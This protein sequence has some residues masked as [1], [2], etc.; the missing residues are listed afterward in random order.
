MR[1]S[2]PDLWF[3]RARMLLGLLF[4]GSVL[5]GC[6]SSSFLGRQFTDFRAYYNTF[7]NARKSFD[8]GVRGL[9]AQQE[10]PIDP[11]AYLTLFG[12]PTR[13]ANAAAFN[14][15][16][17]K[18]AEVVRRH[19][20][21][22]WVDDALMLIGQSYFYLGNY[23]GAAQKFREVIALGGAKELEARF[24][25]ARSLVAARSFDEAQTVLQETLAREA[26]PTD[27]RSR[28]LLLQADLYVQQ[29][30]W[31]E[32]RQALEAGLQRVPERSLG[33]KGYFLL[34]QVC[35]TLQDYACA[36][37]AFDRVRR[38]R[39]DYELAYAA[40]WQAVRIQGLHLDPEAALE[41]L[42]RMERDDKHFARRAELTYL[43][44][45]IYQ[46]MGAVEEA[47][48][49]YHRLLYE[50]DADINRVRGRI[51]YALGELYRDV[52]QDYLAAAAH[53]DTAA[54]ALGGNRRASART[55][56]ASTPPTPL[57]LSDV[58]E[59][60]R[61][62]GQFARVRQEIHRLD[63][64]LYLGSL[65]DEA[66]AAF[67]LELRRRRARELEAQRR[68]AGERAAEQRFLQSRLE[69]PTRSAE[70]A[71][72]TAGGD[73]GFL[74][75]RDPVRVQENRTRF[76]ERWGRRPLVPNWRRR[77]A[78]QGA[79]VAE[80][81][82]NGQMADGLHGEDVEEELPPVDVSDVPRDSVRQAQMRAE[83]ARLR[84]ELGNVLFLSMQRPD[85]AA[86]WYRLVILE[87]ADQ[88]VAPRAYYAL[89]E[90]QRALGDTAA[91][92]ALLKTLL[93]RYPDTPLASRVRVLQGATPP[94]QPT[95][96]DTLA[97]AE[98]A[99]ARAV[100]AW[101]RGRYREALRHLLETA[102]HYPE[103]PVAP[104]AL[105]AVGYVWRD[106]LD[107]GVLA[108]STRLPVA[109]PAPLRSALMPAPPA[110]DTAAVA[111]TGRA[112]AAPD[113]LE[114]IAGPASQDSV[115]VDSTL[116]DVSSKVSPAARPDTALTLV[117]LYTYLTE[118][119]PQ[120]P[121]A[122]LAREVLAALKPPPSGVAPDSAKADSARVRPPRGRPEPERLREPESV[123]AVWTILLLETDN[124]QEVGQVLQQYRQLAPGQVIDVR[125]YRA[126]GR[127]HY[128]LILGRYR[129]E[130][131]AR[132]A[133]QQLHPVLQGGARP[134]LLEPT[135]RENRN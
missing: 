16:I 126:E 45:R 14:K 72:A 3:T 106:M 46:A 35:E 81:T 77:A 108:D 47:R 40:E 116:P 133:I 130:E 30:R 131:E 132:T 59:Q 114:T 96:P 98:A 13:T 128:R 37:A 65:D 111:D 56:A 76:F 44:A 102:A 17:E 115:Q 71:A 20:G 103:T 125:P 134:L 26:L 85:S 105:L 57:A 110:V 86:Y 124:D 23:A 27:W 38:Y 97:H 66:F 19:P 62:F 58:Q 63:S 7:Y 92:S 6:S 4:A 91:A 87:D 121:E 5:A 93:E 73:A 24:W 41:R 32:A 119:Y 109:I 90:V 101:R 2:G 69:Q 61:V 123:R 127:L 12:P 84:Y 99:Y 43:R 64:L 107:R 95:V 8:E 117:R 112:L 28:F 53:F 94:P 122:R 113:T 100:D 60:A 79:T 39:P 82:A 42:R 54:T 18:S 33:A 9:R 52:F 21:S 75:H 29:E 50:S 55:E 89:A 67:V 80:R 88:P 15:A 48:T 1:R 83:R 51:H 135:G 31:E 129:S 104:R 11:T 70:T 74:F 68:R 10:Q 120:A 36:Y 49:L 25:L 118:R 22:K 78:I 34:G